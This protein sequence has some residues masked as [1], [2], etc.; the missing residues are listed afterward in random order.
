ML[1][2]KMKE[3]VSTV[4]AIIFEYCVVREE[5]IWFSKLVDKCPTEFN[6]TNVSMAEDYLTDIC[7]I[8]TEWIVIE[9]NFVNV[10]RITEMCNDMLRKNWEEYNG[11][12]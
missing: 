2:E 3:I 8:T 5:E 9:G 4:A 12:V 11:K 10:Y 1:D 6:R 7:A